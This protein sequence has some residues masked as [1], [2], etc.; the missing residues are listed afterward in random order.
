LGT[1]FYSFQPGKEANYL[2]GKSGLEILGLFWQNY[3][4]NPGRRLARYLF[5]LQFR[6]TLNINIPEPY[7]SPCNN[8]DQ[9][10]DKNY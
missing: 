3:D 10:G 5:E 2:T 4:N 8:I 9:S 1:P 6:E 7:R